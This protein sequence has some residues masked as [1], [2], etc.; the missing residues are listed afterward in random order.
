MS[1]N[2]R[3]GDLLQEQRQTENA[4]NCY[5]NRAKKIARSLQQAAVS[6]LHAVGE[7]HQNVRMTG[8]HPV[9][10]EDATYEPHEAAMRAINRFQSNL[11]RSA[12]LRDQ[13]ENLLPPPVR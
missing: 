4:A 7:D 3:L 5:R 6:T 2:E 8:S 12:D 10:M 13:I 11:S 1:E 9:D